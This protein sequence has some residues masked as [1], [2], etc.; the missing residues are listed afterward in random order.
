M[1]LDSITEGISIKNLL[2]EAGS[3]G[4]KTLPPNINSS[5]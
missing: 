2:D 5:I 4:A 3:M 1:Y